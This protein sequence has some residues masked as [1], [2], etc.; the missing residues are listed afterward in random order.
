MD[1]AHAEV[2]RELLAQYQRFRKVARELNRRLVDSVDREAIDEAGERLGILKQGIMVFDTED[3][4]TVLMDFAVHHVFRDGK[5]AVARYLETHPGP[6]DSEETLV[7]RALAEV[8]YGVFRAARVFRGFAA[9][10]DD[11]FRGDR[12][13]LIDVGMSSTASR[14]FVFAG[15]VVCQGRFWLTTGAALPVSAEVVR[16]LARPV[17]QAFGAKPGDFRQMSR[18]R[19]AALAALVIRT[20]LEKGMAEHI[21]YQEPGAHLGGPHFRQARSRGPEG[22]ELSPAESGAMAPGRNTPC[23]CGSGRRYKHCCGRR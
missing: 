1:V 18:D 3:M 16:A 22:V 15:N 19:Q 4:A 6:A 8:R 23:P 2:Q 11:F 7:L 10:V 5:N 17:K 9:E 13:L 21:A 14:D 12:L 20:C